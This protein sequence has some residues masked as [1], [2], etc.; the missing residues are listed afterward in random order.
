MPNVVLSRATLTPGIRAD[1]VT[2][3]EIGRAHV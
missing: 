2:A 3:Y 1:F